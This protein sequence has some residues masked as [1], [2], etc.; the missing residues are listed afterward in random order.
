VWRCDLRATD[1][2]WLYLAS[3]LDLASRRLLGYA[4]ATHHD[5]ALVCDALDVAVA[6][7]GRQRMGDTIF[8]TGSEY[9]GAGCSWAS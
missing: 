3:V 4:M 6:T 2:G 1:D 8:H 7:R 5:A 9:V